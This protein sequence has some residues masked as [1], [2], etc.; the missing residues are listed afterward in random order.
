AIEKEL[1]GRILLT[2]YYSCLRV[3]DL[4]SEVERLNMWVDNALTQPFSHVFFITFD[5]N[6][7]KHEANL[8]GSL[9]CLQLTQAEDIHSEEIRTFIQ[10][11][12]SQIRELIKS[13]WE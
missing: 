10:S 1:T 7:K 3:K 4:K 2:P 6:W 11:Q 13:Y 9:I 8:N 12:V 5:M